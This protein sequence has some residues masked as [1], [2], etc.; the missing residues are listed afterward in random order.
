MSGVSM[1][2]SW[3]R[4]RWR[5]RAAR[6]AA[7]FAIAP[8]S[9]P[10]T[11]QGDFLVY[12][13]RFATSATFVDR[14]GNGAP[15]ELLAEMAPLVLAG[16][17]DIGDRCVVIGF[18]MLTADQ[19]AATQETYRIVVRGYD[20]VGQGPDVRVSGLVFGSGPLQPPPGSGRG[21]W[22]V[23][24]QLSAPIVVPCRG[25][26]HGIE[27]GGANW[28]SDGQS[29]FAA[30]HVPPPGSNGRGDN[31]RANAPTLAWG[32]QAGAPFRS[33]S[34]CTLYLGL[35][36]AT[37][38]LLIGGIDPANARQLPVGS[39]CF[40]AGGL[41]PDIWRQRRDGLEARIVDAR[42]GG[43]TAVLMLGV[44]VA[45]T[46]FPVP[47]FFGRLWIDATFPWFVLGTAPIA[48]G[49]AAIPIAAPNGLPVTLA[50]GSVTFQALTF[51]PGWTQ[52]IF[53]N[54]VVIGF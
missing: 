40:G 35:L 38:T 46:P 41:F 49:E 39:P 18:T 26:Y 31:P 14:L 25:V 15:R 47:G 33:P 43:G 48:S 34:P 23:T 11:A 52:P 21:A 2:G 36:T 9:D 28:P 27:V 50:F 5:W 8:L 4:R 24:T 13:D 22:L 19:N 16:V 45:P 20:P 12:P 30:Y 44:R 3:M 17:G 53:G 32:V 42:P 7:G 6:L 51:G 37:P 54:A 1:G 10:A 29:L